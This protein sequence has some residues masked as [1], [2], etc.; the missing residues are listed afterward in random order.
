MQ[1][2]VLAVNGEEDP[3]G[4]GIL[5]KDVATSQICLFIHIPKQAAR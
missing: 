1:F 4:G 5:P 3:T 2:N